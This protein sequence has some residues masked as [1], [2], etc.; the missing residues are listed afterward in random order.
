[1]PGRSE[2]FHRPLALSRGLMGVLGAVVQIAGPAILP[3]SAPLSQ[4]DG[5]DA[6]VLLHSHLAGRI[7][8]VM[9]PVD[10]G[11]MLLT[12]YNHSTVM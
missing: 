12:G 3:A 11:H 1:L 7:T 4:V 10:A 9:L 5:A 6:A 8:G 2:P